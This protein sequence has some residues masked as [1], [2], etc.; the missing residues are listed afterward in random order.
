M[1][2][3]IISGI[4]LLALTLGA[5]LTGFAETARAKE[6]PNISDTYEIDGITYYNV[7]SPNFNSD[8][9]FFVDLI[10]AKHSAI[11]GRSLGELWLMAAAGMG[12]DIVYTGWISSDY[13]DKVKYALLNGQLPYDKYHIYDYSYSAPAW[14]NS[15]GGYVETSAT[16][17]SDTLASR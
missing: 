15:G 6:P 9:R 4:L 5:M 14:S 11:G 12:K 10:S 16:L 1:K 7:N 13:L 3:K 2:R 17:N 8:K